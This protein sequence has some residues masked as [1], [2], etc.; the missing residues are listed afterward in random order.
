MACALLLAQEPVERIEAVG[1]EAFV[2]AQPFVG[3]GERP[4]LEAAEMGAAAHLAADQAGVFQRLDVL[5]GGGERHREGL[6]ELPTV[7]SPPASSR[8]I[9]RRVASPRA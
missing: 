4:G 5:G 2:E 3:A 7:R 8:S 1:P 6:G 9:R